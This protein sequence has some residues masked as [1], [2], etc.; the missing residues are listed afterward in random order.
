MKGSFIDEIQYLEYF[1]VFLEVV[2]RSIQKLLKKKKRTSCVDLF[3]KENQLIYEVT[4]RPG[5]FGFG[6]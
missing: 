4:S 1:F 2:L 3:G 6:I 5:K